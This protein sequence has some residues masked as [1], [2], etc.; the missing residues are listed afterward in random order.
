MPPPTERAHLHLVAYG[1]LAVLVLLAVMP[2][3][4]RLDSSWRP[5]VVR[6]ACAAIVIFGCI[7]V[8]RAV[9]RSIEYEPP[10]ALDTPPPA[11]RPPTVDERFLR[12][13]DDLVFS[14]RS[15]RY[16]D[17]FLW[18][19][20]RA[21][22]SDLAPPVARRRRGPSSRAIEHLITEIERRP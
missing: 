20:L 5:L 7:R 13:R 6:L 9:R 11:R 15:R 12:L 19:R 16:F 17:V 22:G 10:S 1:F 8:V 3:Y 14:R 21:L 18:P 4:L 2:G